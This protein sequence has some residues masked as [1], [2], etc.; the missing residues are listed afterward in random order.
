MLFAFSRDGA[1]PGAHLWSRVNRQGTPRNAVIVSSVVAV[2]ITLPALYRAPNG[3]PVA[4]YAVV[5]IGVVGLYVA[6]A[7]PIWFRWRAGDSFRPGPWTL[8]AHYTWMAPVAVAE[9]I[10][11]SLVMML[12]AGRAGVPW[13]SDF[14]WAGV[15]YAPI[16]VVGTLILLWIGWH[17]SAKHWFTGPKHTIEPS[18]HP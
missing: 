16:V 1:V 2:L 15:N 6:F 14:D 7:I 5:S 3:V 9:I 17:T 10:Y 11:T 8:G 13:F 4:F 12:P 18:L